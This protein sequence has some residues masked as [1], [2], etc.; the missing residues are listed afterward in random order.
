MIHSK[1][2]KLC[3][4]PPDLKL[5]GWLDRYPSVVDQVV[6]IYK[7]ILWEEREYG[8]PGDQSRITGSKEALKRLATDQRME[9]VWNELYRKQRGSN[10]F[11][12]P[13]KCIFQRG[14]PHS[15]RYPVVR[16]VLAT[17]HDPKQQDIAV[18]HFLEVAWFFAIATRLR[19]RT[20][21]EIN[22]QIKPYTIMAARL[23][24]DAEA[25]RALHL[26]DHA[27]DL[28]SAAIS[29]EKM[30]DSATS[31][32]GEMRWLFPIVKRSRGHVLRKYVLQMSAHCREAFDKWLPNTVATTA[33]VALSK[34]VS[35][36]QVRE[37]VRAHDPGATPSARS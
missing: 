30:I 12:N 35:G 11:L 27:A 13:V 6:Y 15:E 16:N 9:R 14:L 31:F 29:C 24:E 33:S 25:L 4:L 22:S 18:G 8:Q 17:L 19:L 23:R 28:E 32:A 26:G 3:D 36:D 2:K 37:I 20:E 1:D 10:K 34:N 21:D 7:R 5:P